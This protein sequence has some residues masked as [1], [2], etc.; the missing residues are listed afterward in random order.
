[1]TKTQQGQRVLGLP[2]A[3]FLTK[4]AHTL[5]AAQK[6]H[7]HTRTRTRTHVYVELEILH[8]A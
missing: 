5:Y 3:H 1:M 6:R 7:I 2:R 8:I 4:L